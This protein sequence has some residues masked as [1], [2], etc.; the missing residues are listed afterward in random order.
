MVP[1]KIRV[2]CAL[3]LV[4]CVD[5]DSFTKIKRIKGRKKTMGGDTIF[6]KPTPY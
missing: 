5:F 4:L 2:D 1:H 6:N 3:I